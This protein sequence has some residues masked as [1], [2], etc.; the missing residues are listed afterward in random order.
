MHEEKNQ[1]AKSMISRN[2]HIYKIGGKSYKQFF[3]LAVL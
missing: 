3:I 1:S 2:L